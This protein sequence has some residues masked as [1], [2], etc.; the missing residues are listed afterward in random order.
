ML[1]NDR[2]LVQILLLVLFGARRVIVV[3]AACGQM[4]CSVTQN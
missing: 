3:K 4:R 2:L 1:N